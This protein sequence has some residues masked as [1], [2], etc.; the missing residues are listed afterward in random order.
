L[1]GA[2]DWSEHFGVISTGGADGVTQAVI[3]MATSD[4]GTIA[5]ELDSGRRTGALLLPLDAA[6]ID[7]QAFLAFLPA[8]AIVAAVIAL[9]D[10]GNVMERFQLLQGPAPGGREI[11]V[12]AAT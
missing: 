1:P 3:G 12:P 7:A 10:G 11:P 5:I 2:I 9:D 4:V 6:N 8:E